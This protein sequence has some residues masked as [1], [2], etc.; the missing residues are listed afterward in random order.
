MKT[1]KSNQKLNGSKDPFKI[2]FFASKLLHFFLITEEFFRRSWLDIIIVVSFLIYS[3]FASDDLDGK[4]FF[5]D[6][7]TVAIVYFTYRLV[8]AVFSGSEDSGDVD[9]GVI[10]FTFIIMFVIA[11]VLAFMAYVISLGVKGSIVE[12]EFK[13]S[14]NKIEKIVSLNITDLTMDDQGNF[15]MNIRPN[16]NKQVTKAIGI[17]KDT[18]YKLQLSDCDPRLVY[19]NKE[20]IFLGNKYT[21]QDRKVIC[22]D[23]ELREIERK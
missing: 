8:R 4:V 10:T 22:F 12:Q 20:I 14:P 7:V 5:T 1:K 19:F 2:K 18:F 17:S 23:D 15:Y 6:G 11:V 21:Q 13:N 3:I 9:P 16:S